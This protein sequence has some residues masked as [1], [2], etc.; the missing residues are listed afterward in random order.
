MLILAVPFW[1]SYLGDL[2]FYI[3]KL[4]SLNTKDAISFESFL[5]CSTFDNSV[6]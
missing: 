2:K 4:F 5:L 6:I 1:T 3:R